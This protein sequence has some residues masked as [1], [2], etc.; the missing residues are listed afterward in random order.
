MNR[1]EIL[2]RIKQLED[3]ID[4]IAAELERLRA[5]VYEV[6]GRRPLALR[7]LEAFGMWSDGEGMPNS[8]DWVEN[9]RLAWL[10]RAKGE[11]DLPN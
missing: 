2:S 3:H 10:D 7:E 8:A 6:E 5:E 9:L 4:T 1:K 11:A